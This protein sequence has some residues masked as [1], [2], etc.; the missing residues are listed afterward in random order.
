MKGEFATGYTPINT[1]LSLFVNHSKS[2]IHK[3]AVAI[4]KGLNPKELAKD[5]APP[6]SQ[7]ENLLNAIHANKGNGNAGVGAGV[8]AVATELAMRL[9]KARGA[10]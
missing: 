1:K 9:A 3:D 6:A 10:R 8:G 5:A 4:T 7:F 2:K